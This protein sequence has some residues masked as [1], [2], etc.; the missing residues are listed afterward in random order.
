[1]VQ[2]GQRV[3]TAPQCLVALVRPSKTVASSV[4]AKEGVGVV[5][6]GLERERKGG[7]HREGRSRQRKR[8]RE[9]EGERD[10]ETK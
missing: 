4:L 3:Q 6:F 8:D 1:M 7:A 5:G 2:V 10:R 9:R